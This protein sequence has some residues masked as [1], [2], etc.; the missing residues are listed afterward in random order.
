ME[1]TPIIIDAGTHTFK[2]GFSGK[3]PSLVFPTIIS[4]IHPFFH[5]FIGHSAKVHR[6]KYGMI[7]PV[8]E[9]KITNWSAMEKILENTFEVLGRQPHQQPLLF[10]LKHGTSLPA[11]ETALEI[12]MESFNVPYLRLID[13][14][15]VSLIAH[16]RTTGVVVDLGHTST[17]IVPIVDGAILPYQSNLLD[18]GGS[19]ITDYLWRLLA[20]SGYYYNMSSL[21]EVFILNRIKEK[22]CF[23]SY[24]YPKD[25][26]IAETSNQLTEMYEYID[27]STVLG[28]GSERFRAPEALFDPDYIGKTCGG[29]Q[30][31]IRDSISKCND[32][33]KSTL[34]SSI[35]LSGGTSLLPGLQNRLGN[36]VQNIMLGYDVNVYSSPFGSLDAYNG[37]SSL[38]LGSNEYI[39]KEL[40]DELG[41]SLLR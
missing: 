17:H 10:T 40:Y 8:E 19:D 11:K 2:A 5:D 25:V 1:E 38:A 15:L 6:R 41:V 27:G 30:N 12:L 37:A 9:G 35:Y 28:M 23:V 16:C 26:A 20:V 36:E 39:T 13:H 22:L 24:D 4:K 32:C 14:S 33:I 34:C 29:I 3:K 7:N 21:D 18:F 31:A